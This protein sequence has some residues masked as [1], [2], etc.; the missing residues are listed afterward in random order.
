MFELLGEKTMYIRKLVTKDTYYVGGSDRRLALF[1]N[2]YPLSNGV[3]YNS[4][5]IMDEKTCL[6][7]TVDPSISNMFFEKIEDVLNGKKLDYLIIN[8]MEP[9]HSSEICR[10]LDKYPEVTIVTSDKAYTMFKNFNNGREVKNIILVKEFD[11]LSLG[12]H[13][14]TFVMAPMVHWPEVMVTYDVTTKTLFS[15]DAFGTFGALSGNLFAHE[16]NF[17][18]DYLDEARRYY[19]NIV[20]KYGS[21][22]QAILKK[23]STIEIETICPLH[24]P[25]WRE[26]LPYFFN[27]YDKWSRYEPEVKGV[28]IVYGSIY[29]NS[30]KVAN[31]IA[32]GLANEG[33]RNIHMYDASKTDKSYL[34]AE[35]FKY[36]HLVVVS[37]TYNMGI[38]T[39]VE[40]FLLDLKYHNMQNRT[41]AL[42]ENGSWAPN[43]LCLM[44]GIFSEMKNMNVLTDVCFTVKS[45]LRDEQKEN[46]E[47]L[48]DEIAKDFPKASLD[49]NPLFNITYGLYVL[50]SNDGKRDNGMILN[51]I[52]QV[53]EN[54]N[55]IMFAINKRNYSAEVIKDTKKATVSL[56]STNTPFS[57]FKNFGFQSGKDIDKF[58]NISYTKRDKNGLLYLTKYTNAYISLDVD[59]V[60]DLGSHFGFIASISE[61]KQL[62]KEKSLSYSYYMENIKPKP[63]RSEKKIN[64]WICKICGYIY[65]GED[66]PADFICPLCKHGVADF[67][68]IK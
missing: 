12:K 25:I 23:A 43:S 3:S 67:E 37:S 68:R 54:P 7:D 50:T 63:A 20:G 56:L 26:N 11:T 8:H 34:V 31:M 52:N 2:I 44:K 30:E 39:P 55:K 27:Y 1:E 61:T 40:E 47:T 4:Y 29:G 21:Q 9:D 64:G 58:E 45:A 65:E 66:I 32:D 19:T 48:V 5:I 49:S 62:S 33:I 46:I 53:A 24:G 59:E 13:T 42:V 15:A 51:T 14:L 28:L 10:V 17:D 36:S 6:L 41:V 38:F 22:V 60:M 16:M 35:T 18:H 57:I